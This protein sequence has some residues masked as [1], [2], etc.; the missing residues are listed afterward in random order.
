MGH[1][2]AVVR[3]REYVRVCEV[4]VGSDAQYFGSS[5]DLHMIFACDN[6]V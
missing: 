3:L 5:H 2:R 1:A 4:P 6:A